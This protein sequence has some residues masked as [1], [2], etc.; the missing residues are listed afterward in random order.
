MW[1]A[2]AN[3]AV[4]PV[5]GAGRLWGSGMMTDTGAMEHGATRGRASG[6]AVALLVAV[7][8]AGLAVLSHL[9]ATLPG[10]MSPI[11][12]SA[13]IALAAVLI[14]GRPALLGI[15]VGSFA[16]GVINYPGDFAGILHPGLEIARAGLIRSSIGIGA[17]LAA[18][19][20]A[21]I[22][23]RSCKD[24][25]PLHGVCH[26]V[27]LVIM[28][29]IGAAAVSATV[30]VLTLSVAAIS[31]WEAFPYSWL[32]WFLGDAFGI[33]VAA[34]LVLAWD[35]RSW[36]RPRPLQV[37]EAAALGGATLLLC[38]LVF[39]RNWSV[40]YGLLP[41][42]VWASFRFGMRGTTAVATVIAL[43]ATI[44]T[45]LGGSPF[46]RGTANDSLLAL[47]SFLGV[48][49][50]FSLLLA[51]VLTERARAGVALRESNEKYR[52]LVEHAGDAIFVVQDGVITFANPQTLRIVGRGLVEVLRQPWLA[53]VDPEDHAAFGEQVPLQGGDV[54]HSLT[55]RVVRPGGEASWVQTS[56]VVVPW[57][58]RPA[59]L[60]FGRDV[61]EQRRLEE[62]L[63]QS[64]K[65]EAIGTLAGGIAHDFNNILS[66]ILGYAELLR[67]KL[68]RESPAAGDL[69]SIIKA[70]DRATRLVSQILTF[71]RRAETRAVPCDI[72]P[73]VKE[74]LK[75]LRSSLPAS[76]EI[77]ERLGAVGMVVIDPT[78]LHQVLMNLGTNAY[79]A[80]EERGG[81]LVV[82][83]GAVRIEENDASRHGLAAGEYA[84]LTVSDT[85]AGIPPEAL[86]RIFEPYF[87]TKEAGKGTGLGLSVTHGIVTAAAGAIKVSSEPGRGTTFQVLLPLVSS[88]PAEAAERPGKVPRG[89]ERVLFVDD[90]PEIVAME[91]ERLE[92]LGYRV[93]ATT[94]PE[95]ALALFL[96]DPAQ[97]DIVITD[98][99]MPRLN[100]EAL[101]RAVLEARR[102]MPVL[103]CTGFTSAATTERIAALGVRGVLM[104][105]V[106][107][108]AL[109]QAIRAALE[110]S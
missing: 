42:L 84:R 71:S 86:G 40:E 94:S 26:I 101:A 97:F 39:F 5:F 34:P 68:P 23:R 20:G 81:V 57:E 54:Q 58:G 29:A 52:L 85:G 78:Q 48:T 4:A 51:G 82:S 72:G 7:A 6:P 92:A 47:H 1:L 105:P 31:P 3:V 37:A 90:E 67:T 55:F 21:W 35:R 18:G 83:L 12:P 63:R 74:T 64:Q 104:K 43:F 65:M 24:E 70:S 38:F 75:F 61:T 88:L 77:R 10:Q 17:V 46:V 41:L 16:A 66:V 80:M 89:R 108:G 53:F 91:R 44:G 13:G 33:V 102:R 109:A 19:A 30:G 60:S 56:A 59:V 15:W 79:H 107:R 110:Q 103:I 27:A 98:Q 50:V 11:F 36:G 87:T 22:A 93:S 9:T 2:D 32:T 99:A 73:I 49:I 28:G 62:Q 69:E 106:S 25:H 96:A 95:E 14:L 76:I 8:Y 100:G 45:S